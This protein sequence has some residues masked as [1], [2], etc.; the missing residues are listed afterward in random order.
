MCVISHWV[1]S[2]HNCIL[3]SKYDAIED[4]DIFFIK[5]QFPS[6][7]SQFLY[8]LT[9]STQHSEHNN[10]WCNFTLNTI[11]MQ[12]FSFSLHSECKMRCNSIEGANIL[13]KCL[14]KSYRNPECNRFQSFTCINKK[15]RGSSALTTEWN[16]DSFILNQADFAIF[17][18]IWSTAWRGCNHCFCQQ[19][20]ISRRRKMRSYFV[21]STRVNNFK[22]W[23]QLDVKQFD[24]CNLFCTSHNV[25]GPP[26]KQPN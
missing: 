9:V 18:S 24:I 5:L 19:R 14:I 2:W 3:N 6:A 7:Q 8:K 12:F 16:F 11:S 10:A 13:K 21:L 4:A 25:F 23:T 15:L 1:Q 22:I 26:K 17:D 20:Q